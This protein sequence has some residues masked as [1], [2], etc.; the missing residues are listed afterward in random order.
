MGLAMATNLQRHLKSLGA[1]DL[2]YTNRTLSRGAPLQDDLGAVP[3]ASIADLVASSDIIFLSLSDDKAL[4]ATLDGILSSPGDLA[5]K[6]VVDTS[7][8]LPASSA[9]AAT[10]LRANGAEFV[11]APVF[12]ASPVAA[13]GQLLFIIAGPDAAVEAFEP[14]V[15]GV[16]GRGII[17]LGEDVR[18]AS[19]MK[20][21]G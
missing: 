18:K 13:Q 19:M 20:T 5:G 12:G 1:R 7:T 17:R 4:S 14:F 15:V 3:C 10:R 9:R 2:H 6:I 11:A 21:A 16:M 8:V